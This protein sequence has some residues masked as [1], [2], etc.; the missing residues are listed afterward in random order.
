MPIYGGAIATPVVATID[1]V[2]AF[3][4]SSSEQIDNGMWPIWRLLDKSC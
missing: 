2:Q 3:A 1:C 4:R